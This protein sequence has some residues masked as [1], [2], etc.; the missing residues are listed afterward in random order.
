LKL[1]E[2]SD[3]EARARD[4]EAALSDPS[5]AGALETC[6]LAVER[7]GGRCGTLNLVGGTLGDNAAECLA[8]AV[9]Q[10]RIAVDTIDLRN[11][12][13]STHALTRVC[14]SIDHVSTA[15]RRSQASSVPHDYGEPSPCWVE[16]G[17]NAQ[18]S[19]GDAVQ[20]LRD[21]GVR[22]CIPL[23]RCSR[24]RCLHS[25]SVHL[26]LGVYPRSGSEAPLSG[27][28]NGDSK[29][30]LNAQPVTQQHDTPVPGIV[31]SNDDE[32]RDSDAGRPGSLG[33]P[34]DIA[35][36]SPPPLQEPEDVSL[37]A[38]TVGSVADS[39]LV[40][41]SPPDG[42]RSFQSVFCIRASAGG[43]SEDG[44]HRLALEAF[45]ELEVL[46]AAPLVILGTGSVHVRCAKL[47]KEAGWVST[48]DLVGDPC[49]GRAFELLQEYKDAEGLSAFVDRIVERLGGCVVD[50]VLRRDYVDCLLGDAE[51]SEVIDDQKRKASFQGL[52][53]D[54]HDRM[55]RNAGGIRMPGDYYG[56]REY[57]QT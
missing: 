16:L 33:P 15:R 31:P 52:L 25:A 3:M 41:A 45:E 20:L 40:I 46:T 49:D 44:R 56:I 39:P 48:Q 28:L 47:P 10:S 11:N 5:H 42:F 7:E 17:G 50:A 30:S 29:Q 51:P 12:F 21:C 37:S 38:P 14:R 18:I 2:E 1:K 4:L 9:L 54:L 36:P 35:P 27:T 32:T 23:L 6:I 53:A 57:Y 43:D 26:S 13:L 22:V 55:K 8:D 19:S 34:P 24:R